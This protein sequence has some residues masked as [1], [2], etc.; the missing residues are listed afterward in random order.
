MKLLLSY[1]PLKQ[2]SD[3][4]NSIKI[5][6]LLE[7]RDPAD[8]LSRQIKQI[9]HNAENQQIGNSFNLKQV[10]FRVTLVI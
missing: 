2:H 10:N 7:Y 8:A 9:L 1:I 6:V 5:I 4:K 3:K